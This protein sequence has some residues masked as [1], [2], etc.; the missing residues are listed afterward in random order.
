MGKYQSEKLFGHLGAFGSML[1]SALGSLSTFCKTH[2]RK[3]LFVSIAAAVGYASYEMLSTLNSEI[4]MIKKR[5]LGKVRPK[6][7]VAK[8]RRIYFFFFPFFFYPL[9]VL[10]TL[11]PMLPKSCWR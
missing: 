2:K 11:C 9:F 3:L 1:G 7:D 6:G 4:D 10:R 5:M 8:M